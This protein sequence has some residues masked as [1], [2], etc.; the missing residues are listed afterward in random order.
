MVNKITPIDMKCNKSRFLWNGNITAHFLKYP[1]ISDMNMYVCEC[2]NVIVI[3][4][5]KWPGL[6]VV[7]NV[8]GRSIFRHLK[9]EN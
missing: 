5:K 6:K 2:I 7:Q 9:I 8:Q 1:K 3:K 4:H